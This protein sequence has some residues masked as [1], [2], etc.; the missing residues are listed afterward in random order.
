MPTIREVTP[1]TTE[2]DYEAALIEAAT[3]AVLRQHL[4]PWA[5]FCPIAMQM[6]SRMSERD[7]REFRRG[8]LRAISPEGGEVGQQFIQKYQDLAMPTP[9][10]EA[11]H[12]A[13][14]YGTTL[15]VVLLGVVPS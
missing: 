4:I 3:L 12:R 7:F 6:A 5:R 13:E 2:R 14:T 9:L 15:G 1:D 8:L 11:S 10:M